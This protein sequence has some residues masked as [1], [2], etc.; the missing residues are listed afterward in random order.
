MVKEN[1]VYEHKGN[2]NEYIVLH[3]G[4]RYK[5]DTGGEWVQ[6]VV[7]YQNKEG[8]IFSTSQKRFEERFVLLEKT[9]DVCDPEEILP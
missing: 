4:V 6:N 8:M 2:K 7:V 3:T 9:S 1:F 5:G